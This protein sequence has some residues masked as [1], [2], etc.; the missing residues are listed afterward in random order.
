[1][2][3]GI[4]AT[5]WQNTRGYG[6]HA[7]SLLGALV[8]LDA[9]NRYTFVMDSDESTGLPDGVE[10]R[11][12]GAEAP[13]TM[14][15]SAEGHRSLADMG[16]M[17]WALSASDFD[18]VLF[19]TVYSYVPVWSRARRVTIIHDAIAE[20]Y[21]HLTVPGLSA[22]LLWKTKVSLARWQA[23]VVVTVS[24]Y[25]RRC[26]IDH[27]DMDPASVRVVG[28][29]SDRVFRELESPTLTPALRQRGVSTGRNVAYLGGFNPH[30]NVETLV[31]A[32]ARLA[33]RPGL[34]DIQLVLVGDYERDVFYSRLDTLRS[35]IAGAGIEDRVVF[36]GFV[37]D[38]DLVVLLN[39]STVLVLPS[40]MEGFGLPAV[41]AAACG[42]P[43]IATRESPLPELLGEGGLYFD[44]LDGR[45]LEEALEQVLS[46]EALRAHMRQA[47]LAA[48]HR[49]TWEAA[50][51]QMLNVLEDVRN[52]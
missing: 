51:R 21:P 43:V 35:E 47:G 24:D 45:A 15:A 42:C 9:A 6:R 16:R 18:V 26:L 22:R 49:L 2:H 40:L 20:K 27:F 7:R 14:A 52:V 32:F 36:T 38:D 28:E 1:M 34:E 31:R 5:C 30:K 44:P 8:R 48:A 3:V 11:I 13:T 23:D 4:D 39:T 41:E 19:P 10:H 46:S 12:V 29:A 37:P 25:S 17:S 50:A 33:S